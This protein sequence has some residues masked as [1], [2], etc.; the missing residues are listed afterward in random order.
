MFASDVWRFFSI[1]LS[2]LCQ[3]VSQIW[4]SISL[5]EVCPMFLSILYLIVL[6][7]FVLAGFG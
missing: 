5:G 3:S 6:D 4:K 1:Y 2:R 7:L